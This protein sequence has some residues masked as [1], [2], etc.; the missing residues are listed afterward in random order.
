MSGLWLISYIVLWVVVCTLTLV[1]LA[2]V[3]AI[4]SPQHQPQAQTLTTGMPLG[5]KAPDLLLRDAVTGAQ[6]NL[7][8]YLGRPLIIVFVD[9][10]C[11][12]CHSIAPKLEEYFVRNQSTVSMI[13]LCRSD[14]ERARTFAS[15]T[16]LTAIPVFADP[17]G[18]AMHQ[19]EVSL[20][21][22]A[23]IFR[24]DGTLAAKIASSQL[25]EDPERWINIALMRTRK[26][27]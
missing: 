13:M 12:S 25:G 16:N 17:D 6:K 24:T 20:A 5:R 1:V 2:L 11:P 21:P 7:G 23:M 3:R 14:A 15:T 4:N 10:V 27:A 18:E 19:F 8:A 26:T 22:F 9:A